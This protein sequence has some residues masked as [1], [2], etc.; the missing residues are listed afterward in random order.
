[1][2]DDQN[3]EREQPTHGQL[4][5]FDIERVQL[6]ISG[7]VEIIFIANQ[8]GV[9]Q[10]QA[11]FSGDC[12]RLANF[13]LVRPVNVKPRSVFAHEISGADVAFMVFV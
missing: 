11:F 6:A 13:F 5:L 3:L 10:E 9:F 1:M 4:Y 12:F 2:L 7:L 8:K